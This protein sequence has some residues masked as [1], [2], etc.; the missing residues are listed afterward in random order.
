LSGD[1]GT[2]IKSGLVAGD[3]VMVSTG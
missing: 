1:Q 2:E 3:V